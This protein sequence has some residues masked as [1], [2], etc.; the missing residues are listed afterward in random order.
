MIYQAPHLH[1]LLQSLAQAQGLSKG[2]EQVQAPLGTPHGEG[3]CA[4][5]ATVTALRF[6]SRV[7]GQ[8][9]ACLPEIGRSSRDAGVEKKKRIFIAIMLSVSR[10]QSE[11][12][13]SS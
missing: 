4:Q 9:V 3:V 8:M 1:C 11:M 12:Q 5:A 13:T 10:Q 2:L 6:C 7:V